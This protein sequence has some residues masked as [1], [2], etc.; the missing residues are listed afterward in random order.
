MSAG[1]SGSYTVLSAPTMSS[2]MRPSSSAGI[3]L[4]PEVSTAFGTFA[5]AVLV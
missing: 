2:V 4:E 1:I 3:A 5:S